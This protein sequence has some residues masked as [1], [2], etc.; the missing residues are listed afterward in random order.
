MHLRLEKSLIGLLIA[1]VLCTANLTTNAFPMN[2]GTPSMDTSTKEKPDDANEIDRIVSRLFD[3]ISFRESEPPS[4][5][6]IEQLFIAD[7]LLTDY[8]EEEPLTLGVTDFIE[9]FEGLVKSGDIPSLEDKEIHQDTEIFG[10]IAHRTSYYEAR[11]SVDDTHPFAVGVNSI[12]L[13]KTS[14]GWRI[15]SM[16]WND[17]NRGAGFFRAFQNQVHTE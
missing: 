1:G 4:M 6:E 14:E 10:R 15:V 13:I 16:T 2:T 8:N 3:A 9:H 5:H 11:N 7:G 12:Q 17:D